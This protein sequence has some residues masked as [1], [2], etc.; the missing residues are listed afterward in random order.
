MVRTLDP[1]LS[2]GAA[3]AAL[4]APGSATLFFDGRGGQEGAWPCRLA[5][6]PRHARGTLD[7]VDAVIRRR[8]SIGGPGGTGVAVL[9]A[10]DSDEL[11]VIEADASIAFPPGAPPSASG[12][13]DLVEQ[14]L[15]R[16]EAARGEDAALTPPLAATPRTTLP[17]EAYV[18]GVAAVLAHIERGDIYQ[19]NLTQT[20]RARTPIDAWALHR[21]LAQTTPGPRSAFV[22]TPELALVSASPEIFV[23]VDRSGWAETRPIKGTRPRGATATEDAALAAEL[24]ASEKDRAELVMIVDV[25]RNDLGRIARIGS[26]EVPELFGLRSY[27]TVHHLVARVRAALRDGVTPAD[28]LRAVFPGGSITGAPK[29]RAIEILRSL[30]PAPRG[31]YTGSLFWFDDDGSTVSSIL[32]RSAVLSGGVVSVGAGG[33]VVADSDPEAEW[34]EANA[35]ARALTRAIGFEPEEAR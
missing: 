10:Y 23:D 25:E 17:K 13:P 16:M 4:R 21:A 1:A 24:L 11:T 20:F 9:A 6:A 8:R 26:V 14:A 31:L 33:G 3:V 35:K 12:A 30:E 19:A 15:R 27:P 29:E 7:R 2:L 34:M 22:E 32:I 28:L 5:I 18:R